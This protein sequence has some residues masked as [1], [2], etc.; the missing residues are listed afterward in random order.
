MAERVLPKLGR[1]NFL[2]TVAVGAGALAIGGSAKTAAAASPAFVA[3]E[4]ADAAGRSKRPW[5][6]KTVDKPTME[7]DWKVMERYSEGSSTRGSMPK[8]VGQA[9]VDRYTAAGAK[10]I[11]ERI[12]GNVD[13]YQLRDAMSSAHVGGQEVP[14][15]ADGADA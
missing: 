5:W 3:Q 7:I 6:V 10:L 1:R 8:Y 15:P 12:L 9:E 11:K 14:G 13:G 2:R 4:F